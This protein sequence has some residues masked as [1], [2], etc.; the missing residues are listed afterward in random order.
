MDESVPGADDP[1]KNKA[2]A[3]PLEKSFASATIKK[4]S[5]VCGERVEPARGQEERTMGR[6]IGVLAW[7]V[8]SL[9]VSRLVPRPRVPA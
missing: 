4:G 5:E 2:P 8:V 3:A 9:I 1:S 7:L 6:R